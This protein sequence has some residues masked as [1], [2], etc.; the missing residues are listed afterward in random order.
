MLIQA[1][2]LPRL[3]VPF[4]DLLSF[5]LQQKLETLNA[6]MYERLKLRNGI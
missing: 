5:V 2:M 1:L 6:S 4:N 3:T